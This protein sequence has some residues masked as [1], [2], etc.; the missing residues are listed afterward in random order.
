MKILERVIH[1]SASQEVPKGSH[2]LDARPARSSRDACSVRN[3]ASAPR[4]CGASERCGC[5]GSAI[6]AEG[7]PCTAASGAAASPVSAAPRFDQ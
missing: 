2:H 7:A 3:T 1:F 5:T 4:F 6:L